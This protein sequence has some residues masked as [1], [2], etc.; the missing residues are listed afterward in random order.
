[1]RTDSPPCL[2]T[3]CMASDSRATCTFTRG[4]SLRTFS[5]DNRKGRS[6]VGER[7]LA[8]AGYDSESS[9]RRAL[10]TLAVAHRRLGPNSSTWT[11]VTVRRSPSA[12]S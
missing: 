12:V 7:P 8:G 6:R 2:L 11:S 10:V 9:L 5:L 1:M 4:C 3:G